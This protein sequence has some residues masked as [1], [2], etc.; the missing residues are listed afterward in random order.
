MQQFPAAGTTQ[1]AK[2]TF[3]KDKEQ[4]TI[5]VDQAIPAGEATVHIKYTGILNSEMRG[6][7]L[8]KDDHGRKYAA[9]Q[10]EPTDARRAFPSFDEPN[11]KATLDI[12]VIAEKSL[13]AISNSK[14]ISEKDG[15]GT[16]QRTVRFATTPKMSSYL[17]AL[18]VGN[19]EY[20]EGTA[21]GIPIRVYATPGKKELAKF[22][23]QSAENILKYY[24]RYFGIKYPY[25]KLDLIGLP[26]FSAGAMENTGCIA[27]R[28]SVLLLDSEHA[29]VK[30]KKDVASVIS[31]EMAHQWFGDL[32]TMKW[33]DD[34]WLNGGFATWMSSKPIESWKPEWNGQLDDVDDTTVA[35]NVDSLANTRPIHQA[36]ETPDQIFELFD[37]IAYGKAAAVLQMRSGVTRSGGL[38]WRRIVASA[39]VHERRFRKRRQRGTKV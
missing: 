15:P 14:I 17:A 36:A 3:A 35:L 8:G 4:A 29:A 26:D 12:S 27:Y 28:E 34:I 2:T 19:F 22:A 24:D 11:Y 23:L 31:H 1:P 21:D 33:W 18:I 6:F 16:N 38:R 13:A 5:A 10:F 25:G 7:Y 20:M 9:T 39:R 30:L 32:V 37:G